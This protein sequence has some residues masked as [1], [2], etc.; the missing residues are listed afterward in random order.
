ME[1]YIKEI[2]IILIFGIE[3]QLII[4][5]KYNDLTS[6]ILG[7]HFNFLMVACPHLWS[8]KTR[9]LGESMN[10]VY[11]YVQCPY[12]IRI[13]AHYNK[14]CMYGQYKWGISTN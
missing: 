6:S 13:E 10:Y 2:D 14:C 5:K 9:I 3:I 11:G 1:R 4:N 8:N 7:D 12:S